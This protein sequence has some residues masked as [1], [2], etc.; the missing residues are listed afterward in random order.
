VL[1]PDEE[2]YVDEM[3]KSIYNVALANQAGTQGIRY[4]A[5]LVGRKR[6]QIGNQG[7]NMNTCREGQGTRQMGAMPEFLY[8]I[9]PDGL[10][11]NLFA[12]SSVQWRH[13]GQPVSLRMTTDFPFRPEV[14]LES[15]RPR[16]YE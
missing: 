3:E 12:A 9:A 1:H 5:C 10:Y 15:G 6:N 8:S 11:V 2:K 13:R 7:M 4:T 14:E 16:R